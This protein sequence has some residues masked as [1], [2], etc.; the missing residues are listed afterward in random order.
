MAASP[1]AV[2]LYR[3]KLFLKTDWNPLR[4]AFAVPAETVAAELS[5]HRDCSS[6]DR[7]STTWN[8]G[9]NAEAVCF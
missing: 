3:T 7:Y 8:D 9:R 2:V 6:A 4:Y 5:F 1:D